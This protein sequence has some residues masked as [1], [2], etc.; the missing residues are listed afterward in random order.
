[1]RSSKKQAVFLGHLE[2]ISWRAFEDYPEVLREMIRGKSGLYSLYHKNT[3]Y[4]VGLASNLMGR[5]KAHLKDRHDG[6]WDRFSVYLTREGSNLKE[7]ESLVLRIIRRSGN[8]VSGKLSGSQNLHSELNRKVKEID[9]NRR[10]S[11]LGGVVAQRRRK[12]RA[13]HNRGAAALAGVFERETRIIGLHKGTRHVAVV[14]RDGSIRYKSNH[15]PSPSAAAV[16]VV[17]GSC[18]GWQ[19]WK[20][21]NQKGVWARLATIKH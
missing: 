7:L 18:N 1:M 11:I 2:D 9:A 21:R 16:A 14:M 20:F 5:L 13:K 3:L 10:A 12:Q 19:F 6:R 8:A 4:Y 15:Y 17:G